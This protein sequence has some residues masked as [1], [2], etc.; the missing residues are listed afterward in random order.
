MIIRRA[1]LHHTLKKHRRRIWVAGSTG[2]GYIDRI[3]YEDDTRHPRGIRVPYLDPDGAMI[4][5]KN[6]HTII[7][8]D[9]ISEPRPLGDLV[10]ATPDSF[11]YELRY[12]PVPENEEADNNR[13]V[14]VQRL[15]NSIQSDLPQIRP[16]LNQHIFSYLN[17]SAETEPILIS[18]EPL[19]ESVYEYQAMGK[20]IKAVIF[21]SYLRNLLA[22][23]HTNP[24]FFALFSSVSLFNNAGLSI[25]PNGFKDVAAYPLITITIGLLITSGNTLFPLLFRLMMNFFKSRSKSKRPIYHFLMKK[26][27]LCYTHMFESVETRLLTVFWALFFFLNF[28][29]ICALDWKNL[30]SAIPVES[31]MR[32]K[33]FSVICSA[34]ASAVNVR[35]CGGSITPED[36]FN[37]CTLWSMIISMFFGPFPFILALQRSRQEVDHDEEKR[38]SD[39][40]AN[41]QEQGD[42]VPLPAYLLQG[43]SDMTFSDDQTITSDFFSINASESQIMT[44]NRPQPQFRIRKKRSNK[45]KWMIA[46]RYFLRFFEAQQDNPQVRD[47][48]MIFVCVMVVSMIENKRISTGEVRMMS[49]LFDLVSAYGN[50]GLS[51]GFAS[52]GSVNAQM[53]TLS[54]I[55]FGFVMFRGKHREIPSNLDNAID[56]QHFMNVPVPFE[57][58]IHS[59]DKIGMVLA[60]RHRN[61][62]F[63]TVP[64]NPPQAPAP[65][66]P[67]PRTR[68]RREHAIPQQRGRIHSNFFQQPIIEDHDEET[69]PLIT[70]EI[71]GSFS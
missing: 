64:S 52:I 43:A 2:Q 27:R 21:S 24:F 45:T 36:T 70:R 20:L 37:N 18:D 55:V 14:I 59:L 42:L 16:H 71:S 32:G 26:S 17:L 51:L 5:L 49:I 57:H 6:K 58:I 46:V 50:V 3:F 22:S 12:L 23:S 40:T 30:Y 60:S 39:L 1:Q 38:R 28:I 10:R 61:N 63:Q 68:H 19:Y 34:F 31:P 69:A 48:I 47:V 53:K 35:S 33:W 44:F 65:V 8:T 11:S 15:S 13:E 67:K 7:E 54:Q 4:P 62:P 56:F 66:P 29:F 25:I 41:I 9:K